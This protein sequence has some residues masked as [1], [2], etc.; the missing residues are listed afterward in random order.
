MSRAN[1]RRIA[2]AE[3]HQRRRV[4]RRRFALTSGTILAAALLLSTLF[5]LNQTFSISNGRLKPVQMLQKIC[6]GKLT[7]P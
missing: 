6:K 2:K 5:M 3:V 4:M 7:L 1:T